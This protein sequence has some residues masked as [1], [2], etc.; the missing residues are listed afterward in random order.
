M[1]CRNCTRP[2]QHWDWFKR[3]RSLRVHLTVPTCS[4]V[5]L[6]I[7][8]E[9]R[10]VDP[11]DCEVAAMRHAGA[12]AGEFID[13]LGRSDMATWSPTEWT[14]FIDVICGGYVDALIRQ[15][16]AINEAANKVKGMPG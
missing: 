5:C 14:S 11:N 10:M 15:Q 16:I 1:R 7:C 9:H 13:A 8:G 6:E 3:E 2:A 12:M 4:R